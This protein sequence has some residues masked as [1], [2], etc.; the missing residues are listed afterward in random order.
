MACFLFKSTLGYSWISLYRSGVSTTGRIP[1][2]GI[3]LRF[4]FDALPIRNC[5]K[6]RLSLGSECVLIAFSLQIC[7]HSVYL[8]I[9]YSTAHYTSD[10]LN[11]WSVHPQWYSHKLLVIFLLPECMSIVIHLMKLATEESN[12]WIADYLELRIETESKPESWIISPLIPTCTVGPDLI[13]TEMLAISSKSSRNKND[14]DLAID[15]KN[16]KTTPICFKI[17]NLVW[18]IAIWRKSLMID[19]SKFPSELSHHDN[20]LELS[21]YS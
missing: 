18:N 14:S 6:Y 13:A 9:F 16:E 7:N 8:M 12:N 17:E 4:S 2:R 5:L 20:F 15:P 21:S 3:T 10:F 11:F 19:T 1:T